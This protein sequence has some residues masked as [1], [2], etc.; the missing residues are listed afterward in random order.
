LDDINKNITLNE[1]WALRNTTIPKKMKAVVKNQGVKKIENA[2]N[3][4]IQTI[5]TMQFLIN[6]GSDI[7]SIEFF[8]SDRKIE[9]F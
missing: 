1:N 5:G 3:Y 9:N 2:C 7:F 4:R 6:C 8:G